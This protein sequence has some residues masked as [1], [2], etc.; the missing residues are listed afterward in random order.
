VSD[1][2]CDPLLLIAHPR[3]E[4][5]GIDP[6]DPGVVRA[7]IEPDDAMIEIARGQ[8]A[9]DGLTDPASHGGDADGDHRIPQ[10]SD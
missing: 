4:V 10:G 3:N 9:E 1:V 6:V 7:R 2:A 8:G 5:G